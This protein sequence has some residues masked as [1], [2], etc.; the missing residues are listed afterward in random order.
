M[1][2]TFSHVPN[3]RRGLWLVYT[4]EGKGKTTAALGLALRA[5]GAGLRVSMVQF[6]KGS[7]KYGELKSAELLPHFELIPTGVGFTWTKTPKEHR[8]ALRNG[9]KLAQKKIQSGDYDL[10][11]LDEI[12]NALAIDSFPIEDVLSLED[13]LETIRS[14]PEHVHVLMTGRDAPSRVVEAAD[15]V[16]RMELVKHPYNDG[17]KALRGIE[18]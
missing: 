2:S 14:R 8:E 11:I 15:L 6:I 18:Y 5:V 1:E 7:M 17:E 13:V 12:N 16:T 10:V 4:G 9:W 3:R